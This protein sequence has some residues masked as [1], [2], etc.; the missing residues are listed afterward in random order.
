MEDVET[1]VKEENGQ[2]DDIIFVDKGIEN[3]LGISGINEAFFHDIVD[4]YVIRENAKI[5]ST[6]RR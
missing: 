2:E 6:K 3:V 5:R 4:D 1:I